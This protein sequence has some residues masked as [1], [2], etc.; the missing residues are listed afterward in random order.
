MHRYINLV[1]KTYFDKFPADW[2]N[3]LKL[4]PMRKYD[5][6]MQTLF[7]IICV[8]NDTEK[9]KDFTTLSENHVKN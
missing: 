6:S 4:P 3:E 1:I 7:K 8:D 5:P 2:R 9:F